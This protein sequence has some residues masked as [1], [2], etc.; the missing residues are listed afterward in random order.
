MAN[1]NQD[2]YSLLPAI[3]R[4]RDAQQNFQLQSL[5]SLL[6]EQRA[7]VDGHIQQFQ[8]D[9]FIETCQNWVIPY[10]GDLVSNNLLFDPSRSA[11]AETAT[12]LFPDLI[13][14][15]LRPPVAIRIRADVA[16][17]IHYRRRKATPA[18][19]EELARDVTGW[20]AHVVEFFQLL[21]WT[22]FL[23]HL[24]FQCTWT[25][26]RAIDAME[27]IAGA[28]D[29]TMH[30]VDVRQPS[31]QEGWYNIRNIGFFLWRLQSFP[32]VNVPARPTAVAWR[33][34]FSPL[35]NPAPLFTRLRREVGGLITEY[36]VPAPIR[37]VLFD[38]D[39][40][41]YAARDP[42]PPPPNFTRLYGAF[43]VSPTDPAVT[44]ETSLYVSLN[45]NGIDP[46][47]PNAPPNTF[48]PQIVCMRLDPWPATQP[49]GKIVAIDVHTGRLAIG[50]G[51]GP[52]N[53]VDVSH[54]YGFSSS[55]GGGTYD[56]RKW[57]ENPSAFPTP[58]TRYSVQQNGPAGTFPSVAAALTQWQNATPRPSHAI[59][60]IL[61]NRTY[62]LP[63]S[64]TLVN[65]TTLAIEA[66]QGVRPLLQA[67]TPGGTLAIDVSDI[68]ANDDQRNAVFTL[69]GVILEGSIHVVG[70]LG[71]LRLLHSTL[72]PGRQLDG[73]G[74]P[75][76][77]EPSVTVE[78]ANATGQGLN[79]LLRI[80]AAFSILGQLVVPETTAGIWLLDCIVQGTAANP[81]AVSDAAGK[82]A[83]PLITERSTFFGSVQVKSLQASEVIFT[84]AV[85]AQRTQQGCVRFS[86]VP[87]GSVTPRRYR[88]QPDVAVSNAIATALQADPLLSLAAQQQIRQDVESR[89]VPSF[90]TTLY[91]QPAYAQLLLS[92]PVEIRTGAED[93][94]EMGAF[95]HLKQPQRES[96][97]KIRLQEYLP[98]GL[99]AAVVYV[100]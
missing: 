63:G 13:G 37:R 15:D 40:R 38:K 19:L 91:G 72:I 92:C 41:D 39:L 78:P 47:D 18:M 59:I 65:N 70:D 23:E 83:A 46:A 95:C 71:K 33:Y 84:A 52:I 1:G 82:F 99:D 3:Y 98:F 67:Q 57:L 55:L 26:V 28:F 73:N 93:G 8:E 36:D 12:S 79:L 53:S 89:V 20:P 11:E 4:E 31:Q 58:P 6:D 16:K 51:W 34:H 14:K 22:Q 100:T 2:L 75:I 56:R 94:S 69:N 97:L 62:A 43:G 30:T 21:G 27:R 90:T 9:L 48:V 7:L 49:A 74:N 54:W 61:D 66:A 32:L 76:S 80:E 87:P 25:D 42:R 81:A 29:Q 68:A 88:C 50:A 45:G 44:S 77:T 17:T 35:G 96:N 5:L 10:I 86:Y 24:R 85:T 60:S 64:I